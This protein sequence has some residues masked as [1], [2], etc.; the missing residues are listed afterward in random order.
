MNQTILKQGLF[1]LSNKFT[2]KRQLHQYSWSTRKIYMNPIFIFLIVGNI[3]FLNLNIY[4]TNRKHKKGLFKSF[5][6]YIR[7][8]IYWNRGGVKYTGKA[9]DINDE[10]N[11]VVDTEEGTFENCVERMIGTFSPSFF[12]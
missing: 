1:R 3:V 10:G 8:N 12:I 7:K 9:V 4:P 11:L 5:A 2:E 6:I